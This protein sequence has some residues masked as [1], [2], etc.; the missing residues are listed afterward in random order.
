MIKIVCLDLA[1]QNGIY[2]DNDIRKLMANLLR[3]IKKK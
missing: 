3:V 1:V 2:Y